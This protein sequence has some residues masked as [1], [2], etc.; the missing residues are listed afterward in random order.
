MFALQGETSQARAPPPTSAS[1]LFDA[2][3]LTAQ[4]LELAFSWWK[5]R[6][7]EG[8]L[9]VGSARCYHVWLA[10]AVG[11]PRMFLVQAV[12]GPLSSV[13]CLVV[14]GNILRTWLVFSAT[15]RWRSVL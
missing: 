6:A 14:D 8:S 3:I 15:W 10:R 2:R 7:A 12:G 13:R 4:E 1:R 9:C 5:A 11:A